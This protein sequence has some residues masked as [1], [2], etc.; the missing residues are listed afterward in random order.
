MPA[1]PRQVLRAVA[2]LV[3]SALLLAGCRD[4]PEPLERRTSPEA[5]TL[6][7]R[8]LELTDA[9]GRTVTVRSAE[10]IVTLPIPA[11]SVL[12]AVDGTPERLVGVHPSSAQAI[13]DGIL[14]EIFPGTRSI[15]S[16]V[17]TG[18]NFAPNV[19]SILALRPDLVVQ[20]G[21]RG[22]EIITP[23]ANA[24]LTVLGL[25]YGTQEDLEE[26]IRQFG[27]IVGKP[28]RAERILAWHRQVRGALEREVRERGD[29]DRPK[30]LYF[31]RLKQEL[32]VAG[33][34]TF[35]DFYINLVGGANPA[36]ALQGHA[37]V[38]EEQVA[39]WNPDVILVGT[40]DGA[41]PEDVYRRPLWRQVRAVQTRRVY[42]VPVGGYRWDPPSHEAPLMWQWLAMLAHPE[43]MRFDLRTEIA[44]A[45]RLF[46]GY[47]PTPDQINRILQFERNR[48]AAHYLELFSPTGDEAR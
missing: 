2:L 6:Q 1:P 10:R 45:Y 29:A 16:D 47:T 19:E 23:L 5:H 4:A 38:N 24:G 36:A 3:L 12:I 40:F 13:R 34:G 15:P 25:R 41:T 18:E 31:L 7:P 8:P 33:K 37:A 42:Q 28:E 46:Y 11:A 17:V 9:T 30:I 39:A 35:N 20:W 26:W 14:G 27:L 21:D 22:R 48:D 44:Q 32:R 43:L